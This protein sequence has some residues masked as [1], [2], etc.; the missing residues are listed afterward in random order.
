M[1]ATPRP[2]PSSLSDRSQC[3]SFPAYPAALIRSNSKTS[4]HRPS[5]HPYLLDLYGERTS[6]SFAAINRL[7]SMRNEPPPIPPSLYDRTRN[8]KPPS[9]PLPSTARSRRGST[10]CPSRR[11]YHDELET[12]N[13]P[14]RPVN[15]NRSILMGKYTP[16]FQPPILGR[17]RSERTPVRLASLIHSISMRNDSPQSRYPYLV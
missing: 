12:C 11:Y 14:I 2:N 1:R 13:S 6:A 10:P 15:F 17:T 9:D 4:T 3:G 8:D 5:R 16:S 7:I